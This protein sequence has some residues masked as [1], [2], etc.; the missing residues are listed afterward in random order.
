MAVME[1]DINKDCFINSSRKIELKT[2]PAMIR[3]LSYSVKT[4]KELKNLV[5]NIITI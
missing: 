4:I 2:Y 3:G 1:S 5:S